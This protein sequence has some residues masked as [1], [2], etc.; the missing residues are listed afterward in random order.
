MSLFVAQK[1]RCSRFSRKG[2]DAGINHRLLFSAPICLHGTSPVPAPPPHGRRTR[3]VVVERGEGEDQQRVQVGTRVH[4]AGSVF[5][6]FL[7]MLLLSVFFLLLLAQ[8]ELA[9]YQTSILEE[10]IPEERSGDEEEPGE[11]KFPSRPRLKFKSG[12]EKRSA[13][14]GCFTCTD[15]VELEVANRD[16]SKSLSLS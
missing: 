1:R 11:Q 5:R 6:A 12:A 10:E 3:P 2:F 14:G 8:T 9:S 13:V 16:W 15:K 7:G 4:E